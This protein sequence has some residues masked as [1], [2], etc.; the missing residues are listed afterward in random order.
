MINKISLLICREIS[1]ALEDEEGE[2]TIIAE[3]P[4]MVGQNDPRNWT[5]IGCDISSDEDETMIL[6]KS[7]N[8]KKSF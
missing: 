5:K 3:H 7:P 2:L 8:L 6:S 4:H 1:Y